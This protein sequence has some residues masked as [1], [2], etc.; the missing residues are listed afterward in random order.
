MTGIAANLPRQSD[1]H[2]WNGVT[3]EQRPSPN[4]RMRPTAEQ[5]NVSALVLHADA[6]ASVDHSISWVDNDDSDVSYHIIIGRTG[7]AFL[8]VPLESVAWAVGVSEFPQAT[9]V[10]KTDKKLDKAIVAKYGAGKTPGINTRSI[11]MCFGNKNDGKEPYTDAQYSVGAKLAAYVIRKFPM[12]TL[13]RI[14]THA[15]TALPAGRKNDP[16]GFD[17]ERFKNL[18]REELTKC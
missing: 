4:C 14:T 2:V 10:S 5:K 17:L 12:I 18:V 16:L 6:D 7:R 3:V 1:T 11:S 15:V 9:I 13:A 8:I